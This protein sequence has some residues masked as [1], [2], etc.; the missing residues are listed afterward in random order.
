MHQMLSGAN[1]YL[2]Y[3]S[4]SPSSSQIIAGGF[5]LLKFCRPCARWLP[6]ARTLSPGL[7]AAVT[8]AGAGGTSAGS[9]RCPEPPS[10]RNSVHMDQATPQME[11]VFAGMERGRKGEKKYAR[12]LKKMQNSLWSAFG[13]FPVKQRSLVFQIM[14]RDQKLKT[15]LTVAANRSTVQ[16]FQD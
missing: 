3:C 11:E 8:G 7:S 10:T 5:A 4:L 6:A 1:L 14:P 2:L 12:V 13:E 15:H 9:A 16:N